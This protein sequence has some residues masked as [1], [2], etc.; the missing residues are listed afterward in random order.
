MSFVAFDA[1]WLAAA[2]L[3]VALAGT[4]ARLRNCHP[5]LYRELGQP[6]LLPRLGLGKSVGLTRFY[7]SRRA[8]AHDDPT[9][10]RWITAVRCHQ[11]MLALVLVTLWTRWLTTGML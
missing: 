4:L 8:T 5:A 6:T 1:F 11:C 2:G 7:W 10:S 9:L 3:L